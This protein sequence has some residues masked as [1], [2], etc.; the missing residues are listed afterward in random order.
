MEPLMRWLAVGSRGYH[1]SYQPH[2]N[3]TAIIT[4]DD[5]GYADDVIITAGTI[6]NLKIQLKKLQLFSK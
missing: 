2:K 3:T 5:R 6:Q 1:P 4:Y